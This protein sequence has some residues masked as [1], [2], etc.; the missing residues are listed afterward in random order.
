MPYRLGTVNCYLVETGA[1]FALVD[2]GVS[3][4]RAQLEQELRNAG[5]RPGGLNLIALTHGDFDHTGNAAHLRDTF[6][7]RIAMHRD[8]APMAAQGDMFA[9]RTSAGWLMRLMSPMVSLLFQFPKSARFRPD[10]LLEDGDDLT[11]H[12]FEAQV[13]RLPGHSGGS[14]GFLT[15]GGDLFC[16]DLLENNKAPALASIMDDPVVAAA[17]VQ[18]LKGLEIGLVYPGHGQPFPM[19][20]LR[21]LGETR[22]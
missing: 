21:A 1:G 8:D 19:A 7:A 3:T 11:P 17:T 15:A 5:C 12:G 14:I 20:Q 16:G 6:G 10:L 18:A 13:I 4:R 22:P 2:T 9:S